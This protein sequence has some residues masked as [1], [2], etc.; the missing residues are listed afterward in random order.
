M[1]GERLRVSRREISGRRFRGWSCSPDSAKRPSDWLRDG[2]DRARPDVE[3]D[4]N[5]FL[6]SF[7]NEHVEMRPV[8]AG[9]QEGQTGV[10]LDA[11][12]GY[13]ALLRVQRGEG[14]RQ[15]RIGRVQR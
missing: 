2:R 11:G 6:R 7:F 13:L 3:T 14:E 5:F 9:R 1:G 8:G 12:R 15:L 4:S 10:T